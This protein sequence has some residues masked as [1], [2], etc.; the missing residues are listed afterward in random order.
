MAAAVE[1]AYIVLPEHQ[2]AAVWAAAVAAAQPEHQA[3]T[4][5]LTPEAAVAAVETT[6]YTA[7]PAVPV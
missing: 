3:R 2:E 4:V 5:K 6:Q 1:A 7:G